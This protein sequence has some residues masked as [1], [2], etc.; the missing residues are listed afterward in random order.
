MDEV[1]VPCKLPPGFAYSKF[2]ERC[3]RKMACQIVESSRPIFNR[4]G[5]DFLL[6]TYQILIWG[7]SSVTLY[8]DV[9][10]AT[11][12]SASLM[13]IRASPIFS[14]FFCT[15]VQHHVEGDYFDLTLVPE[16]YTGYSGEEAH[17]VW[18]SIYEENC[19]GLSELN[20]MSGK[21]PAPVSLPNTMIEILH[22]DGQDSDPQCLEKRVYY[23]VISGAVRLVTR[24]TLRLIDLTGLHAS[25]STHICHDYLNQSTGE[26]VGR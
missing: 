24:K 8:L 11:P 10:T 5:M 4:Q 16:R 2:T 19:F 13:I 20:L 22:D 14:F 15:H 7:F 25:I 18:R 23:K 21:A 12:I 1:R 6:Q 3:P 26:W 17:R 9:T